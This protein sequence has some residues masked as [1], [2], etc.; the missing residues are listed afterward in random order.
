MADTIGR[1]QILETSEL[2]A[3]VPAPVRDT[4]LSAARQRRFACR[5]VM[6]VM[7]DPIIE[8]F[9][10]LQGCIKVTQNTPEG[11]EIALRVTAPGELVG[12]LGAKSGSKHST[13]AEALRQCEALA[14][15]REAFDTALMRFPILQRNV[16]N[17]LLRHIHDME[18]RVCCVSTQLACGRLA[19]ELIQLSNQIGKK[20]NSHVEIKIPQEAL[21]QMTA[22]NM[23]TVNKTL[24]GLEKQGLLR[25]RRM[26]I[27]VHDSPGLLGLCKRPSWIFRQG[28][29]AALL[30]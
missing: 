11:A 6:F 26:C 24:R 27:E 1:F 16:D 22:M 2:F 30:T 7:G 29:P 23:W 25:I 8:T 5:Q 15:T 14:W 28:S 12:E 17:I 18:E 20:V 3:D 4:I 9:L 10:L 21:A 13:T 19:S